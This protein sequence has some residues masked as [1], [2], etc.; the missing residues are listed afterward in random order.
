MT[1]ARLCVARVALLLS[2]VS[3]VLGLASPANAL[4]LRSTGIPG[5][6]N[7]ADR[8]AG[9]DYCTHITGIGCVYGTPIIA[10]VNSIA[11]RSQAY[12]GKQ[13]VTIDYQLWVPQNGAWVRSGGIQRRQ[14]TIPA[15]YSSVGVQGINMSAP[16]GYM[17]VDARLTWWRTDTMQAIGT[18]TVD[19]G[20][21]DYVCATSVLRCSTGPGWVWM[22]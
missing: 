16:T 19:Y 10:G 5:F 18:V 1:T 14:G 9:Q 17:S 3:G 2:M 13:I 7:V 8:L 20:G 6:V 4:T 15:G 12:S 11:Y 22:S 21:N